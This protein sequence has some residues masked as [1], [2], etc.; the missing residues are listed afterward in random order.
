M[1]DIEIIL[2][3]NSI[4]ITIMHDYFGPINSTIL[5]NTKQNIMDDGIQKAINYIKLFDYPYRK[6]NVL[7]S[8]NFKTKYSIEK[9]GIS[10]KN[11]INLPLLVSPLK[12]NYSVISAT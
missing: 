10:L 12:E 4:K 8:N 5:E 7:Y 2:Q 1:K 3:T 11:A 6:I 9:I